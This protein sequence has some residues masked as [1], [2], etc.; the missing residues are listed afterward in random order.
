MTSLPTLDAIRDG[1]SGK[2]SPLATALTILFEPSPILLSTLEPQLSTYL[3]SQPPPSVSSYGHLIDLSLGEIKTWDIPS[4]SE[5]ISGHPRI[6]ESK[7]LSALSAK[8]QGATAIVNL[9]PP[10]VLARLKHLNACYEAQYPGLRYITFVNG[11]S[12]AT[13]VEEME[14]VL[15][16]EHSLSPDS[17][18][19][20]VFGSS[21]YGLSD[22]KWL[23]ELKRAVEDV[24]KI[25]KN[26][27]K[28]LGVE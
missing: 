7:N 15:G 18:P 8:E 9:T 21:A 12:R 14:G 13:I 16:I 5:F 22:E 10:E 28:A 1:P 25:A 6:G 2:E 23:S 20:D 4:Q 17:P 3:K 11:R 19:V 24:G 27:L 26:R